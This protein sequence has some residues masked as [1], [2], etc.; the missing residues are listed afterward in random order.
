METVFFFT[1]A[2]MALCVISVVYVSIFADEPDMEIYQ[3]KLFLKGPIVIDF[4]ISI[5][6]RLKKAFSKTQPGAYQHKPN[7]N[8]PPSLID[9]VKDQKRGIEDFVFKNNIER[10]EEKKTVSVLSLSEFH[11]TIPTYE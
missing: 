3:A 9:D 5:K 1:H 10:Q 7:D 6:L 8:I 4:A 11:T 2:I